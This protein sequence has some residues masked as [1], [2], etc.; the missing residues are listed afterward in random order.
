MEMLVDNLLAYGKIPPTALLFLLNYLAEWIPS[1][2]TRPFGKRKNIPMTCLQLAN[3]DT[4]NKSQSPA[5]S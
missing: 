5:N 1:K 4:K 2:T 3:D